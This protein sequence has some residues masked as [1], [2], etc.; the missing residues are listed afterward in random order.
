MLCGFRFMNVVGGLGSEGIFLAKFASVLIKKIET[1]GNSLA[2]V[3]NFV[4]N[5]KAGTLCNTHFLINYVF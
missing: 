1:I 5:E 2:V 4:I 3:C